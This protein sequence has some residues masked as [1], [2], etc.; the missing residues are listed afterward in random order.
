MKLYFSI[1]ISQI[2]FTLRLI[3]QKIYGLAILKISPIEI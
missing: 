1:Y 3:D 2:I